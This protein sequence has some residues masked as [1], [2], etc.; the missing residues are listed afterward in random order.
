ML[1][2]NSTT[3][4]NALI[5]VSPTCLPEDP[6]ALTKLLIESKSPIQKWLQVAVSPITQ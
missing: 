6:Q 5:E 3:E 1:Y 2:I 4:K